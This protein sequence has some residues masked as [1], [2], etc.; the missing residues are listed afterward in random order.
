MRE[1]LSG[2]HRYIV[3]L[4]TS[5]H[6]FFVFLDGD[7]V[8]DHMLFAVADSDALVLGYSHHESMSFGC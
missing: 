1:A 8:A 2:L 7:V 4:E 3:T 6:R 5:K